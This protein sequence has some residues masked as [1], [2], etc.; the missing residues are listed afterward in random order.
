MRGTHGTAKSPQVFVSVVVAIISGHTQM[1]IRKRT[2]RPPHIKF[3]IEG[4]PK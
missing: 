1:E 2:C 3:Q 4:A